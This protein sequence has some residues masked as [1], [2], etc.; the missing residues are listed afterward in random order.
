MYSSEEGSLY[1]RL[2]TFG[3]ASVWTGIRSLDRLA[4]SLLLQLVLLGIG[5]LH[6][7]CTLRWLYWLLNTLKKTVCRLKTTA[8]SLSK[9]ICVPNWKY[10]YGQTQLALKYQWNTALHINMQTRAGYAV[11]FKAG[12]MMSPQHTI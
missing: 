2:H 5:H 12:N 11:E 10:L 3:S 8:H 6:V 1:L 7:F 4:L 9:S